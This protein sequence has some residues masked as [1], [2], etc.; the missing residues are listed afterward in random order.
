MGYLRASEFQKSMLVK[1]NIRRLHEA[2]FNAT[3]KAYVSSFSSGGLVKKNK[4]I[5]IK[6]QPMSPPK[7]LLYWM[8]FG[9]I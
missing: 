9:I 6:P 8:D 7:G 3:V 2:Y 1:K 4:R 5:L